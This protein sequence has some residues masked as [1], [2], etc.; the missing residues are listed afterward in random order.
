MG[1]ALEIGTTTSKFEAHLDVDEARIDIDTELRRIFGKNGDLWWTAP[2]PRLDGQ[3]PIAAWNA[4][5]KEYPNNRKL[6]YELAM[7]ILTFEKP[8]YEEYV[9]LHGAIGESHDQHLAR[10]A[11]KEV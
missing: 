6:I 7:T 1:E 2:N 9:R 3:S 10:V 11:I 4:N 8:P 5:P